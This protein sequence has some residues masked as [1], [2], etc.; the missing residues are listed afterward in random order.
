MGQKLEKAAVEDKH[1]R[2]MPIP[3]VRLTEQRP[4]LDLNC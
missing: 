4:F 1:E 2:S 3:F